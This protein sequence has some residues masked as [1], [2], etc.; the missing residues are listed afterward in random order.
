[1]M[2]GTFSI[3]TYQITTR[4]SFN[5]HGGNSGKTGHQKTPNTAEKEDFYNFVFSIDL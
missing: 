3:N 5:N 1:M 4:T 2:L